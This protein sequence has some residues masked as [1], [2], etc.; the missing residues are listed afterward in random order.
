MSI[1]EGAL[2]S[3]DT[4]MATLVP[5][6]QPLPAVHS[7]VGGILLRGGDLHDALQECA[8]ALVRRFEIALLRIWIC[9]GNMLELRAS[10]G[11][12]THLDGTHSRI[13]VGQFKVGLIAQ[14]RQ[15]HFADDLIA[16][17]HIHDKDWV[18]HENLRAFA[19]YPLLDGEEVVGVIAV[20]DKKPMSPELLQ[21]LALLTHPFALF[22]KR[23]RVYVAPVARPVRPTV[24][25]DPDRAHA[26]IVANLDGT[27]TDWNLGAE[28]LFGYA[29][30]EA[31]GKGLK[32]LTPRERTTEDRDLLRKVGDDENAVQPNTQRLRKDG[33][34][35]DVC[36]TASPQHGHAGRPV[37][38]ILV[39]HDIGAMRRL[40]QQLF[41][42]QK[43]EL[44]GQLTG[45]VAHD[46]NN[47]L[48][49]I[50]GYSEILL[51]RYS[52]DESAQDLIGEIRKAGQ[53]RD[54]DT[55][56]PGL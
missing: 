15:P 52:I 11:L 1:L 4:R 45:G 35:V 50:L 24:A 29:R 38:A 36:L 14:S 54:A 51:R 56:T 47:L 3:G 28:Q 8:R 16:D 5:P 23:H 33:V 37:G 19:G 18:R 9:Q 49:V 12:Y 39:A 34:A 43:M 13:P 20:F 48:T 21:A 30:R 46:F 44:F 17:P 40:Q 10:A 55:A 32:M 2:P 6:H 41:I 7:E 53:R 26:V 31:I 22:I 42:A 27:I 25:P